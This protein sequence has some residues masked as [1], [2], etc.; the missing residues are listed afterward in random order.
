MDL[1]NKKILV[2]GL[3]RNGI[4]ALRALS[5][6]GALVHGFDKGADAAAIASFNEQYPQLKAKAFWGGEMPSLGKDASLIVIAGARPVY[7][8]EIAFYQSSGARFITPL[9]LA[10]ALFKFPVIGITGTNGKSTVSKM[11]GTIMAKTGKSAFIA[12]GSF[13]PFLDFILEGKKYDFGIF[14]MNS[15]NLEEL[16]SV[17]PHIAIITMIAPSHFERHGSFFDYQKAK[18][19][20]TASQDENNWLVYNADNPYVVDLAAKSK[21]RPFAFYPS[22]PRRFSKALVDYAYY[23]RKSLYYARDAESEERFDLQ[24]SRIQGIH[25]Y[26]N[27]LSAVAAAR[28]LDLPHQAVQLGIE[29]YEPLPYRMQKC[30]E[31]NG[32]VYFNDS[33]ASNPAA[34]AWGVIQFK[35]PI[36]LILGGLD[37]GSDFRKLR[38]YIQKKVKL[39]ILFGE[40]RRQIFAK[41]KDLT[42]TYLVDSLEEAVKLSKLKSEAGDNIVFSPACAPEPHLYSGYKG[43]GDRFL[44]ALKEVY[45]DELEKKRKADSI[46]PVAGI[47]A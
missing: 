30:F 17:K 3:N 37:R 13:S 19:K 15:S 43:R 45:G 24:G 20:I 46:L 11:L 14:E 7:S 39:L 12:G 32:K 33:A 35:K 42:G 16:Q 44:Q 41:L 21:A 23:E 2:L 29:A 6:L 40:S 10:L 4:H 8:E 5:K 36:I 26:L 27:A 34:T 25:N 28:L 18:A 9:E 31:K 38:I 22:N 47:K 1:R